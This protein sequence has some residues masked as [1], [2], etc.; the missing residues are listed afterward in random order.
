MCSAR[1]HFGLTSTHDKATRRQATQMASKRGLH[2]PV[3]ASEP[4]Y[5]LQPVLIRVTVYM[6]IGRWS[7]LWTWRRGMDTP[8]RSSIY[9]SEKGWTLAR[10]ALLIHRLYC[11]PPAP[12]TENT[13]DPRSSRSE[14]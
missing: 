7:K 12:G 13:A 2:F 5:Q 1:G 10:S 3:S 11:V 6:R 14:S 8:P 9:A 4:D